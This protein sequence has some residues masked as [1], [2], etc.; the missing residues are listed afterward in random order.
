M[1]IRDV[2]AV[3]G[4]S[5]IK[6]FPWGSEVVVVVNAYVDTTERITVNDTGI[7]FK[8]AI[9]RLPEA[10]KQHLMDC[11]VSIH[12]LAPGLVERDINDRRYPPGYIRS[13][14]SLIIAWSVIAMLAFAIVMAMGATEQ[15]TY[16][17]HPHSAGMLSR[18]ARFMDNM[19]QA[20][21][22]PNRYDTPANPPEA[23]KEASPAKSSTSGGS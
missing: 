1:K 6:I 19:I 18:T 10:V 21:E 3:I 17:L 14:R 13:Y 22:Q 12:E 9:D 11:E 15:E 8:A 2:V 20:Y 5:P 4:D 16:S 7:R 23:P